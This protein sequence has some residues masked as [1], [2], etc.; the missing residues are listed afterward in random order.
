MLNRRAFSASALAALSPL[1]AF[2]QQP[3]KVKVGTL[4]MASLATAYVAKNAGIFARHGLDAELVEFRDGNEAVSAHQGGA[5]DFM[6]TIPGTAMSASERSFDLVMIMQNETARDKGPDV[7]AVMV[8]AD[9]PVKS[10]KDLEGKR[11]ALG[12]V[13]SQY[14]VAV[15]RVFTLAGADPRKVDFIN[16]PFFTMA[17]VLRNG[18]I[19]AIAA[20]D[21]WVTQLLSTGAGRALSW[22]YAESIPFQPVGAWYV[23]SSWLE[24]NREATKRFVEAMK[25]AIDY[26]HA[27]ES[28]ARKS[29][30]AFT[31]MDPALVEKMPINAWSYR[32]DPRK[33]QAVADM[34]SD[35]GLLEKKHKAEEYISDVARPY[36]VGQ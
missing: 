22:I 1:P 23:K 30:A 34:L 20:L 36:V 5:V 18:G 27:D 29:V 6:L 32:I 28:R 19:D 10:L 35:N 13:K 31:G 26:M 4:K 7:G 33:W 2:A 14:S 15:E 11:V 8:K 12:S 24:K 25:E 9:S 21:P 3:I 16:I 17:D